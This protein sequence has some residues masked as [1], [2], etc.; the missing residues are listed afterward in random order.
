M[1]RGRLRRFFDERL[2]VGDNPRSQGGPLHGELAGLWKYRI[3]DA[4]VVAQIRDEV[5][6]ILVVQIGNRREIYR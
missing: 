3:G 6:V 4:R 2:L 5:L 1:D